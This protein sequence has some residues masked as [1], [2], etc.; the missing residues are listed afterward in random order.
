[1]KKDAEVPPRDG[2]EH[3]L[4]MMHAGLS[5]LLQIVVHL[6]STPFLEI[7]PGIV[8]ACSN[9]VVDPSPILFSGRC[10][11]LGGGRGCLGIGR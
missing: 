10:F 1:M 8:H 9:A 4:V 5:L 2:E 3:V 7:G 6:S 11:L